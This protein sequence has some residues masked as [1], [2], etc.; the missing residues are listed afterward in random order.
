MLSTKEKIQSAM[1]TLV[2]QKGYDK[3]S[4]GQICELVGINKSSVYYFYKNKED[5]FISIIDNMIQGMGSNIDLLKECTD[6]DSY[7]AFFLDQGYAQINLYEKDIEFRRVYTEITV[8][9]SRISA[10]KEKF[11]Q[12][13]QIATDYNRKLL[14]YGNELGAFKNDFEIEGYLALLSIY[15]NGIQSSIDFQLDFDYLR[16]YRIFTDKLMKE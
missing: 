8:Q 3:T 11:E 13:I 16:A 4:I 10:V 12:I 15:I 5:I 2:A 14:L 6:I 9:S 1:Y 7:K